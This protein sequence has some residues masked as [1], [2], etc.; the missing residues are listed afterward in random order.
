MIKKTISW[1]GTGASIAGAFFVALQYPLPGYLLFSVGTFAWM[2][3]GIKNKD[4][5][6]VTLNCV[7]MCANIIG[8][9][10]AL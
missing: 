7:F 1:I 8:I 2:Y 10:K 6:L 3:V 5:P 4:V 9:V